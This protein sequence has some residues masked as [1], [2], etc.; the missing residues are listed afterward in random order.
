VNDAT[1][2]TPSGVEIAYNDEKH[3]YDVNGERFPSITTVLR[4]IDKSAPLMAWA[5]KETLEG[6]D[7]K[8]TRDT[9]ATRGTSVHDALEV[10]ARDGTPPLLDQYPQEDR[11]YV[12]ALAKWWLAHRPKALMVEQIVAS[13]SLRVA[14]RFDLLAEIGGERVLCDLKTSSAVH[15]EM[16]FQIEAYRLALEECGWPAADRGFIVRVGSDG[17][18]E[19][20]E[21]RATREDFVTVAALYESLKRVRRKPKKVAA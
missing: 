16:H 13:T 19:F 5:V 4:V 10:L 15:P 3:R 11:G 21:S 8:E 20:V 17:E 2:I 18:F 14:G 12:Q 6:R 1:C 7:Y 9:A